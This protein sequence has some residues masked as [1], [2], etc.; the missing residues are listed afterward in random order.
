MESIIN[1]CVRVFPVLIR[2]ERTGA[3]TEDEI[4]LT[5][6]QLRTAGEIGIDYEGLICRIYNR[7]G[8]RV[9]NICPPNKKELRVDLLE[10]YQEQSEKEETA[11]DAANIDDGAAERSENSA[12]V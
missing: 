9:L 8:Y 12:K 6:D 11:A 5:K 1:V 2:D 3:K 7:R 4:A 10:L